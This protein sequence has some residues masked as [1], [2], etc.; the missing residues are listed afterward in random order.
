MFN[1]YLYVYQ[2][3]T[4]H[5]TSLRT[6]QIFPS[7]LPSGQ[8]LAASVEPWG[9]CTHEPIQRMIKTYHN[10]PQ[11][12]IGISGYLLTKQYDGSWLR[13]MEMTN[14]ISEFEKAFTDQFTNSFRKEATGITGAWNAKYLLADDWD[15]FGVL[16]LNV[17]SSSIVDDDIMHIGIWEFRRWFS[18]WSWVVFSS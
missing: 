13:S 14:C 12:T 10:H 1:S 17:S 15:L 16:L 3:G 9:Y 11:L 2:R 7:G 5:Y 4:I 8:Q 6:W 18:L